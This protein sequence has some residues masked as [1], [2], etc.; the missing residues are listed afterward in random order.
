MSDKIID[1]PAT[2]NQENLLFRG[3]MDTVYDYAGKVTLTSALGV[4]ELV[5][6]ALI[7]DAQGV[8]DD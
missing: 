6:L 5:K 7:E 3:L 2:N 1:F 8:D 4:L